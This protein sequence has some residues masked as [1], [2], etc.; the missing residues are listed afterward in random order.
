MNKTVYR[1]CSLPQ[2]DLNSLNMPHTSTIENVQDYN[3]EEISEVERQ[4]DIFFN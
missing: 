4:V 2:E 3:G 1:Y